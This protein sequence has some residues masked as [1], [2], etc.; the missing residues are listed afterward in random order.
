MPSRQAGIHGIAVLITI[1]DVLMLWTVRRIV[2]LVA[3]DLWI[4]PCMLL[5]PFSF[6]SQLGTEGALSAFVLSLVMLYAWKFSETPTWQFAFVYSLA[7]ALAVLSRLDNIFIV[8]FVWVAVWISLGDERRRSGRGMQM[9]MIPI[10]VLLW[11]GYLASNRIWFHT[12]QPISGIMKSYSDVSHSFR[13]HFPH[14]AWM[15]MAVILVCLSVCAWKKRD[16]FFR[17]VE[18]PFFLA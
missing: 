16:R 13:E 4:L 11:G 3:S 7:S 2:R 10:Y 8:S 12:L 14:T 18:I 1:L 5:I 6:Q 9:A 15:A 17:V